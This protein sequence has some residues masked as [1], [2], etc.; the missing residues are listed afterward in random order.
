[1]LNSPVA[2]PGQ[3]GVRLPPWAACTVVSQVL[4]LASSRRRIRPSTV[5]LPPFCNAPEHVLLL[6]PSLPPA[7]P[8]R[9]HV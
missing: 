7:L 8:G 4:A 6:F 3:D 2:A 5:C 9:S 1:M